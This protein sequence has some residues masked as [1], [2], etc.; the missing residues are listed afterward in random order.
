MTQ[1]QTRSKHLSFL[2]LLTLT[3]LVNQSNQK[4]QYSKKVH[5]EN[6]V[7]LSAGE[8]FIKVGNELTFHLWDGFLK[9]I[10]EK[11]SMPRNQCFG[12]KSIE[13]LYTMI[14]VF[15]SYS[16]DEFYLNLSNFVRNIVELVQE[17][18]SH[19][20]LSTLIRDFREY[21]ESDESNCSSKMA[22]S[23]LLMYFSQLSNLM[24]DI[25]TIP[26]QFGLYSFYLDEYAIIREMGN[27]FGEILRT[28]T[29]FELQ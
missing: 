2:L 29:G 22:M 19:C 13:H 8:A 10:Y 5:V 3:I 21:C 25:L 26:S 20:H 15:M 7:T 23:R 24:N 9:G 16:K 4:Q 17:I 18:K 11:D 6:P 1:N 14:P 27:K 12:Q 28:I